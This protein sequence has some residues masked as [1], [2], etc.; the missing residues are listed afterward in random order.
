MLK[1]RRR[2]RRAQLEERGAALAEQIGVAQFVDRVLQVEPAQERI[3]GEFRGAQDVA[4][5]VAFDL[6]EGD[7][8]AHTAIEIAPDPAVNR[9]QHPV[10][11]AFPVERAIG[12]T[13]ES[14]V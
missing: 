5:A 11:R 8:L 1:Q 2:T 7:Q 3:R 14:V 10:E 9:S 12:M 4:P 6:R 13:P